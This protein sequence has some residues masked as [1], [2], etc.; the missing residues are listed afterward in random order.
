MHLDR[1][2]HRPG[3]P[4]PGAWR[5]FGRTAAAAHR[6]GA[7]VTVVQTA[8]EDAEIEVE[9]VRCL[10]VREPGG[11]FI[12]LPGGRMLRRPPRRLIE[13]VA[14]LAPA[15]IHVEGLVLPRAVRRLAATLP[16]IPIVAQDHGTKCPRGWRRWWYRWGF[17]PLAGV[18]FTARSQAEPFVAAG[19]LRPDLPVF[20]VMEISS[21]FAP[22]DQQAA[23]SVTGLDGDPCL[24]WAGNL[25]ANK[26]PLTVLTAVSQATP[27]LAGLRL[28]M[29]FRH[30]PLLEAV[31]ARI[32][33]DPA[34]T[35][36]S[37]CSAKC[38]TPGSR[39]TIGPPISSCRPVTPKGVAAP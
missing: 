39:P 26:D 8:W 21:P 14:A 24:F 33:G 11:P 30:A 1:V 16:H 23:R 28:Y 29:C 20:E 17:A 3:A 32:A 13:R 22:G 35:T 2:V 12:R 19:I 27:K 25:D 15:V 6:A 36:R 37:G 4:L 9:G 34:L 5:N 31:R 10:L 18:T 7:Q 38:L